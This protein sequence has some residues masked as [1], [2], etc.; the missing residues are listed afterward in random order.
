MFIKIRRILSLIIVLT[1]VLLIVWVS[2]PNPHQAL[3][4]SIIPTEMQLPSNGQTPI[5]MLIETRQISLIWPNSMRIGEIEEI[6]L[7]FKPVENVASST[8]PQVESSDIYKSYNVMSEARFEVAG[9]SVSPANPTRESMPAG[10]TVKFKWQ[11][12]TNQVGSYDGNVWLSLRFLPLNGTQ[13]S[14]VPIFIHEVKI[15]SFSLFGMNETQAYFVGGSGVALGVVI[16]FGDMIVLIRRWMKKMTTKA[17][18]GT[19]DL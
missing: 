1:S 18:M 4:Q 19:K 8:K 16:I 9:I 13:A 7:V 10:Q 14:Q 15:Q 5:P 11:I 2:L 3:T 17:S 12:S 6:T